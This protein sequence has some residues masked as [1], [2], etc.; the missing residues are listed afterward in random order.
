MYKSSSFAALILLFALSGSSQNFNYTELSLKTVTFS[1]GNLTIQ[2]DEGTGSYS[3]PQWSSTNTGGSPVAYVS[4]TAPTV[5]STFSLTCSV[6]P[7]FVWIKGTGPES[8][9]FS[10]IK[11]AVEPNTAH[12]VTYPATKGSVVFKTGVV[13]F[14][15]PFT[16]FWQISFDNGLSWKSAGTSANTLYVTK[17]TPQAANSEYKWFHTVFDISC[18]NANN[19]STETD[20]ISSVWKEFTDHDVLNHT[21]DS[22][23]FIIKP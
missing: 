16:I 12:T 3:A 1:G 18:R 17:N 21:G 4:G 9:E 15:K 14:F 11:V 23:Y 20:I 22:F 5:S 2:K 10:A 13:R 19:Q 6:V 7:D 8:M